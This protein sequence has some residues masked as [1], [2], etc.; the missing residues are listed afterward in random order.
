VNIFVLDRDPIKA[1]QLNCDKHVRKI[2]LEVA[3]MLTCAHYLTDENVL[4]QFIKDQSWLRGKSHTNNHVTKWV[5]ESLANYRWAA[6]HGMALCE[7]YTYRHPKS[8]VHKTQTEMEWLIANEPALPNAGL[9]EFR[10][11]VAEDCYRDDV[12]EAYIDYYNKYKA[13]FAKWTVRGTPAW[14]ED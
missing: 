10:Q 11:A 13:R 5:R 4:P 6:K 9:T 2:I 7:E 3:Q 1:A 14:F 12:V 8:R